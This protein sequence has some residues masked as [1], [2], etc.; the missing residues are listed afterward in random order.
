MSSKTMVTKKAP[1]YSYYEKTL[2]VELVKKY[3]DVIEDKKNNSVTIQGK[4]LAW[5]NIEVE[6]NSRY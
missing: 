1:N 6:F 5:D 2:I 3:I 4:E